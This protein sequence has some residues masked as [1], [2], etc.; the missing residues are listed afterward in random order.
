MQ[1]DAA[2]RQGAD[3]RPGPGSASAASAASRRA[4]GVTHGTPEGGEAFGQEGA[5]GS[6]SHP[7]D[8]RARYSLSEL[9]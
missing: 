7:V 1:H 6:R 4:G 3:A 8:I 9:F 5:A 2:Q